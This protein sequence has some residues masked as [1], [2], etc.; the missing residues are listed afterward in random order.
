[1]LVNMRTLDIWM[2]RADCL[3]TACLPTLVQGVPERH[4]LQAENDIRIHQMTEM[5]WSE[6]NQNHSSVNSVTRGQGNERT[7]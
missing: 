6:N 2:L 5:H 4:L 3:A 1:M 7:L